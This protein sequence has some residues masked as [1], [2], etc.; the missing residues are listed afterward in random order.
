MNEYLNSNASIVGM[1]RP[2]QV[3][4]NV[5]LSYKRRSNAR[6]LLFRET[7]KARLL[8]LGLPLQPLAFGR[9][10]TSAHNLPQ[11]TRFTNFSTNFRRYVIFIIYKVKV[12]FVRKDD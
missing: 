3:S 11:A 7:F 8:S 9:G 2:S 10:H 1:G 5:L 12:G 4:K 6:L